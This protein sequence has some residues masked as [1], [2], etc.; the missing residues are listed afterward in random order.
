MS[1]RDVSVTLTGVDGFTP[2]VFDLIVDMI[3]PA[4]LR[5]AV[6]RAAKIRTLADFDARTAQIAA[7]GA[8]R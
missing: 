5:A 6:A 2:A 3:D 8:N 1:A 4:E 7:E